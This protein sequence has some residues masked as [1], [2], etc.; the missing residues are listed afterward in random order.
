RRAVHV[1]RH[2][3]MPR[4]PVDGVVRPAGARLYAEEGNWTLGGRKQ[5]GYLLDNLR[6]ADEIRWAAIRAAHAIVLRI[7]HFGRIDLAVH[8]VVR[9]FEEARSRRAV[10]HLAKRD[11]HHFRD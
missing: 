3:E 9:N 4:K 7:T 8:D 5:V 1:D 2:V 10:I 11:A 6:V